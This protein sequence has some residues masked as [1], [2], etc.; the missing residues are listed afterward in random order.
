MGRGNLDNPGYVVIADPEDPKRAAELDIITLALTIIAHAH[1]EIH[2]GHNF[3]S[4]KLYP[5]TTGEDFLVVTP[6]TTS[7]RAHFTFAFSSD[8]AINVKIYENTVTS[9][10][11]ASIT[12]FNSRRDS[13]IAAETVLTIAPTVTTLGT[14]LAEDALGSA[15][16]PTK[17]G[18]G[19]GPRVETILNDNGTKYL[20]RITGTANV[21]M[22]LNWYEHT[23]E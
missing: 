5:I 17:A 21:V 22:T 23:D 10:A 11:G 4:H 20:I 7:K 16:G 13:E 18:A 3:F 12:V 2:E 15:T 6:T 19:G 14:L 1:H 9:A 8:A